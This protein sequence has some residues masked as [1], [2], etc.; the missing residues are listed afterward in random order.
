MFRPAAGLLVVLPGSVAVTKAT[1]AT[2]KKRRDWRTPF[3]AALCKSP[4]VTGAAKAAGIKR[5]AAYDAYHADPAFAADWESAI[6]AALDIA[7]G[8]LYR[9]AVKGIKRPATIAGRR[10]LITEHSDTLLIFLLKSHRP[11]IYRETLRQEHSGPGGGP[12]PIADME[13]IRKKRW[14]DAA[15]ALPL[16]DNPSEAH[17]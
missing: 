5:D 17:E 3:L 13:V 14:Q 6:N 10:E 11:G 2:P 16:V 15:K 12:I 4:N 1:K 7:E 8:E 9:R